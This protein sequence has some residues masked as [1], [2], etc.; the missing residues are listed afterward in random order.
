MTENKEY[1]QNI[2]RNL[3]DDEERD[4][5]HDLWEN[6][7]SLDKCEWTAPEELSAQDWW[8]ELKS[9][10]PHDAMYAGTRVMATN[11]PE[12]DIRPLSPNAGELDRCEQ[13]ELAIEYH[14]KKATQRG[15]NNPLRE[16]IENVMKY[17]ACG[18][19]IE[20]LPYKFKD[21]LKETRIKD[22]R[23]FGDYAIIPHNPQTLYP[24]YDDYGITGM[25]AVS[26]KTAQD[27]IDKHGK[28]NKGVAKMLKE[29][30]K[31]KEDPGNVWYAYEDFSDY[32]NRYIQIR[33]APD[34]SIPDSEGVDAIEITRKEHGLP[35]FPW[36]YHEGLHPLLETAVRVG[37][38]ENINILRSIRY[39]LVVGMVAHPAYATQTYDS[40]G[41]AI[42]YTNPMGTVNLRVG[43]NV[44]PFN[45]RQLDPH[46]SELIA[47][48]EQE[49]YETTQIA[50]VLSTMEFD[51]NVPFATVNV[52]IQAAVS[53]LAEPRALA[54]TILENVVLQMLS[55][56]QHSKIALSAV[57]DTTTNN[58]APTQMEGADITIA[59]EDFN[60]DNMIVKVKMRPDTT[61]DLSE[62]VNRLTVLHDKFN[63]PYEKAYDE[64]NLG[65][66]KTLYDAFE[67]EQ[68]IMTRTRNEI[69]EMTAKTQLKIRRAVAELEQ[70]MAEKAMQKQAEMAA[71]AAGGGPI[72]PGQN[73]LANPAAAGAPPSQ[74]GRPP[75]QTS[76]EMVTGRDAAGRGLQGV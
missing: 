65:S 44:I 34:R 15:V 74:T 19:Q 38:Y 56:V 3:M 21:R 51:S 76:R 67:N 27:I 41:P 55:W 49:V 72:Q 66:Y 6:I 60:M 7:D 73:P 2:I 8:R 42:D 4:A 1:Y 71:K 25:L 14:L 40:E 29:M 45:P 75:Q 68:F 24:R 58:Y 35:F 70:E 13:I 64:L 43:E 18:V 69:E 9:T 16:I 20:Y 59:P 52:T 36:V 31:D 53:R 50:R 23:R 54:E 37:A 46:L 61:T 48:A 22:M 26:L 32:E 5:K 11:L 28:D 12:I 17:M 57:R 39:A 33:Y 47:I 30:D 10:V 63:Y 62:K